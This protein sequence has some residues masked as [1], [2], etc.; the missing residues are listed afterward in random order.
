MQNQDLNT[1][2]CWTVCHGLPDLL[3]FT[4]TGGDLEALQFVSTYMQ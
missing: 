3:A 1:L 2:T 4:E